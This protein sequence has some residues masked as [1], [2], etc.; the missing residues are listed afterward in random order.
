[1]HMEDVK[2]SIEKGP[3]S[4]FPA[5]GIE[6]KFWLG[7]K[8]SRYGARARK[9]IDSDSVEEHSGSGLAQGAA[10][11]IRENVVQAQLEELPAW[12][13]GWTALLS[14]EIIVA[15]PTR[16]LIVWNSEPAR[17]KKLLFHLWR[18]HEWF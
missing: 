16:G 2:P 3:T 5:Q 1:M 8:N 11:L 4:H 13:E 15:N 18:S 14:R 9:A 10:N 17:G 12:P 6:F 7:S